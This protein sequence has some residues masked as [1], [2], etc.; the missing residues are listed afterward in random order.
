MSAQAYGRGGVEASLHE[1]LR[2]QDRVVGVRSTGHGVAWVR[3]GRRPPGDQVQVGWQRPGI[4]RREHAV[5]QHVARRQLPVV[6]YLPAG[7]EAHHVGRAAGA[8]GRFPAREGRGRVLR[9]R[10]A[11]ATE[12][13]DVAVHAAAVHGDPRGPE[14]VRTADVELVPVVVGP[15]AAADLRIGDA[16]RERSVRPRRQAVRPGERTEVVVERAVLL[17]DEDQVVDVGDA[18]GRVD[19]AAPAVAVVAAVSAAVVAIAARETLR[20]SAIAPDTIAT[21]SSASGPARRRRGA[22]GDIG[23]DAT[24]RSRG[25]GRGPPLR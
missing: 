15:S 4:D 10:R 12:G 22:A 7:V 13:A 19:R 17:H 16:D 24:P 8:A 3:A 25:L 14:A 23:P 18:R 1:P 21:R 5:L 2:P 11:G 9:A 20:A 6:R